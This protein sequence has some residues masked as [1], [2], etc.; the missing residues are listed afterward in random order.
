MRPVAALFPVVGRVPDAPFGTA[1]LDADGRAAPAAVEPDRGTGVR[2]RRQD[3]VRQTHQGGSGH[4]RDECGEDGHRAGEDADRDP[5][6][7]N[8]P[9]AVTDERQA[10]LDEEGTDERRG[11]ADE[12]GGDERLTH[13]VEREEVSHGG[14]PGPGAGR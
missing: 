3:G 9:D 6:E 8:V 11:Q 4:R 10:P 2:R 1:G 7:G 13:E 14:P 5:R 12:Q